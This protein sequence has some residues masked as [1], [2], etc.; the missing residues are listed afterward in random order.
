VGFEK[1]GVPFVA[2]PTYGSSVTEY[3]A[4]LKSPKF[5]KS[6]LSMTYKDGDLI[7]NFEAW[8]ILYAWIAVVVFLFS[9]VLVI[10]V[11]LAHLLIGF[12]ITV[13]IVAIIEI[14]IMV[15]F[16]HLGWFCIVK[17]DSGC[18]KVGYAI[19]GLWYFWVPFA[20]LFSAGF[21]AAYLPNLILCVPAGYMA[22]ICFKL[23]MNPPAG[24]ARDNILG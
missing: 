17:N 11:G 3:S 18:G 14:I 19:W 15:A 13:I 5:E 4:L 12:V 9:A 7:G 2:M 8:N 22:V 16:A 1:G 24:Q 20:T 6:M 21:N 10:L 23:F